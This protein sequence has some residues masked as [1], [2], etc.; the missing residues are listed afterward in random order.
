MTD[1]TVPPITTNAIVQRGSVWRKWDLHVHTPGTAREDQFGSWDEYLVALRA[2]TQVAVVGVTDYLSIANYKR[3]LAE[4]SKSSLGSIELL[5]PNVEFRLSPQTA[6]G[7]AINLHLLIDP[8]EPS[9]IDEIELSL[10]RLNIKYKEQPYSCTREDLIRLGAAF[11]SALQTDNQKLEAGTNQF[12][13]EFPSFREWFKAE[14]WLRE[15]S[16]VAVAAGNDGP[17]GLKES[18]W[19]AVQEE[20]WRFADIILSANPQNRLFWLC[21]DAAKKEGAKKLGAPK[22]CVSSSDAHAMASLFN[23]AENR[24]CWVK[25]DATFEGLRAIVYEPDERVYIWTL[26]TYQARPL[27]CCVENRHNRIVM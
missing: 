5:I 25:A 19:T 17:S 4:K 23:P 11:D 8:T 7:S 26:G 16:L 13:V 21:Q 6:K 1:S 10:S 9:H 12:K 22:P 18:G 24:F 15:H 3:L 2:E 20:I 27:A 14:L